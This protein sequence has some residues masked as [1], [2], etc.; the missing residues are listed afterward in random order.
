MIN[1]NLRDFYP[2]YTQDEFIEVPEEVANE[3]YA[4]LRYQK[5]QQRYARLNKQ[6]SLDA[7]DGVD[8]AAA[9]QS[10]DVHESIFDMT[11]QHC[12]LC[13]AL[14]SLPENQGRRVEAHYILG[15]SQREIADSEG[16]SERNVRHSLKKGLAAMRKYFRG[17]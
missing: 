3:L 6:L 2:W 10:G 17:N 15:K 4:D 13:R 7:E 11:E 16:V 12:A 1:I 14:N 8:S 5:T 9:M